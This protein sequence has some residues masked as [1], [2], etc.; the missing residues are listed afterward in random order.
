MHFN[1]LLLFF[2]FLHSFFLAV[3]TFVLKYKLFK[4]SKKAYILRRRQYKPYFR[5]VDCGLKNLCHNKVCIRVTRALVPPLPP[6]K[7]HSSR[8]PRH[9]THTGPTIPAMG[10]TLLTDYLVFSLPYFFYTIMATSWYGLGRTCSTS[11]N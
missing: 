2:V 4:L 8:P 10:V 5:I 9:T 3:I 6:R 1:F 7:P 11:N